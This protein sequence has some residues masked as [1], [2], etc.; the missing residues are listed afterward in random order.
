M[1]ISLIVSERVDEEELTGESEDSHCCSASTGTCQDQQTTEMEKTET[2][3]ELM[4]EQ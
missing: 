2:T 3:A 1:V 4:D